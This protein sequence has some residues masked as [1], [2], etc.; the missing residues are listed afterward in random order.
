MGRVFHWT[1]AFADFLSFRSD[2]S[3]LRS[4]IVLGTRAVFQNA[5]V[6]VLDLHYGQILFDFWWIPW[7]GIFVYLGIS[8]FLRSS[9][10]F[11]L[12]EFS[13]HST[14]PRFFSNAGPNLQH[15]HYNESGVLCPISGPGCLCI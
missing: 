11:R 15:L 4:L 3:L 8:E 14:D 7:A 6:G 2:F 10:G 1:F 13:D 5:R 12:D 9:F